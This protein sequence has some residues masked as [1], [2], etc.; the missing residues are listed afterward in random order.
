MIY[1]YNK[2][3]CTKN[4][5][6][7][8]EELRAAVINHILLTRHES[9]VHR[10]VVSC[11][12]LIS[13]PNRFL[14]FGKLHL[15]LIPIPFYSF[16]SPSLKLSYFIYLSYIPFSFFL[17]ILYVSL[18]FFIL[19]IFY[20]DQ[21]RYYIHFRTNTFEKGINPLITPVMG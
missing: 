20:N 2:N 9:K 11:L 18:S 21:S 16:I 7:L 8:L 14:Y 17:T 3:T 1:L 13:P 10:S 4:Q 19:C 6:K 5:E 12:S 15:S